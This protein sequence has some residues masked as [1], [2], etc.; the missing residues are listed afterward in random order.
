MRLD[1]PNGHPAVVRNDPKSTGHVA[2][3]DVCGWSAPFAVARDAGRWEPD[4]ERE[5]GH[6]D[7]P[8]RRQLPP[9]QDEE[10]EA[11]PAPVARRRADR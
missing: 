5:I 2:M 4:H 7:D 10:E 1:C 3:C 9:G 6:N 8:Q 11:A